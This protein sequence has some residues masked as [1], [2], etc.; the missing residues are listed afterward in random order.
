MFFTRF[1][2]NPFGFAGLAIGSLVVEGPVGLSNPDGFA[3]LAI[4][5]LDEEPL[6]LSS[7]DIMISTSPFGLAGLETR[8]DVSSINSSSNAFGFAGL[9][10]QFPSFTTSYSTAGST[11][12]S[13]ASGFAGLDTGSLGTS[14]PAG[15]AGL[16]IGSLEVEGPVGLSNPDGFA[17]LGIGPLD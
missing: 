13:K 11:S 17:G 3:G 15:F 6:L 8:V 2:S 4:G 1:E 12:L 10:V 7:L 14:N 16:A 9:G 5:S